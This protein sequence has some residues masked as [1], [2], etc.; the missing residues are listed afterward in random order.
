MRK[1]I[2][3]GNWKMNA[4]QQSIATLLVDLVDNIEMVK[5]VDLVVFPPHP[6]LYQ[7][8]SVLAG[9]GIFWGAQNAH[10]ATAGAYTGE[11]SMGMVADFGSAYVLLGHSERRTMIGEI[12]TT[13]AARFKAALEHGL[14]PILCVGETLQH[15]QAGTTLAVVG[16]Q[17]QTVIDLVGARIVAQGVLA[18][19]P[20][21]AIGT[22]L[23]ATPQQAQEVHQALRQQLACADAQS[24]AAIQILYGGSVTPANA[25]DLFGQADIDGAL[26][27]G[28]SLK[29]DTFLG[30][31]RSA[32]TSDSLIPLT[33][34]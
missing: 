13:V 12:D 32:T 6:Y 14:K 16:H 7:V 11:T 21:W 5:G 33:T 24:A 3:A 29:A 22:G 15:R 8:Q 19:E 28:A 34:K 23:T 25:G 26:V 31:G 18:Y 2:V 4:C 17:L 10:E 1:M 27:G 30:I 9:T 20:V